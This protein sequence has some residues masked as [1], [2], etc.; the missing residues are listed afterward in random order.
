MSCHS[1]EALQ[2]TINGLEEQIR[3][4]QERE[5][6]ASSMYLP[7][8]EIRERGMSPRKIRNEVNG[9]VKD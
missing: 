5:K 2:A 7:L 8:S 6:Q 3:I 4:M 1:C 9:F